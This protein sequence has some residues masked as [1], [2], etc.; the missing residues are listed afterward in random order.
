[1]H[2]GY[3]GSDPWALQTVWLGRKKTKNNGSCGDI[4]D[5]LDDMELPMCVHCHFESLDRKRVFRRPR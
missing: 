1:M 4:L 5:I 2:I 3:A